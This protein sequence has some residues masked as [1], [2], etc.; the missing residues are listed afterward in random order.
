MA[1]EQFFENIVEDVVRAKKSGALYINVVENSEDLIRIYFKD[2]EIYHMR[3]GT[4]V[5]NDCLE[6]LEYYRLYDAMFFDGITAPD[7]H[8][9][10]LPPTRAI[11]ERIRQM[12]QKIKEN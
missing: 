4:A 11:L 6:V 2:G 9:R 7:A 5:G 10:D 3:Y 8:A 12:E 1:E